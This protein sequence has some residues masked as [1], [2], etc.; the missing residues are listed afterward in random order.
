MLDVVLE[1]DQHKE[2]ALHVEEIE[3]VDIKGGEILRD[4]DGKQA[5]KRK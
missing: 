2:F 1:V 5:L 3:A 4:T